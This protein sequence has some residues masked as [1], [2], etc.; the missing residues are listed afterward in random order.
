MR[1]GISLRFEKLRLTG[2]LWNFFNLFQFQLGFFLP[3]SSLTRCQAK[4][5]IYTLNCT[6]PKNMTFM[7]QI[8]GI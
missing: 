5:D 1:A 6:L 3:D 2:S 8:E 4:R 7:K